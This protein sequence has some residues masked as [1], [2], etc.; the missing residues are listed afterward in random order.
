[1]NSFTERHADKIALV[2]SCFDRVVITGS[3]VDVAYARAMTG[4]LYRLGIPIFDYP[5]WANQFRLELREH[6]EAL[7]RDHEL[8]I[9]FVAKNNFRKEDRVRAI[10]AERGDHPGL[11]HIFSAM[12]SCNAFKPW[13]DK[14]T[15][16]TF[17][18]RFPRKGLWPV[19]CSSM[20][21]IR[22][23]VRGLRQKAA[24]VTVLN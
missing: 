20:G 17:L 15:H 5:D 24:S 9:E 22:R 11:V 14:K 7:A 6:A 4:H 3:L 12:E 8:E 23:Y 10:I 19:F 16:K 13:H 18:R 21:A 2:L 1:M